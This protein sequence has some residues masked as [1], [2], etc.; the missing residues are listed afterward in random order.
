MLGYKTKRDRDL[1]L[2]CCRW[3]IAVWQLEYGN[4]VLDDFG[5]SGSGVLTCIAKE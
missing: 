2:L 1:F 3:N 5:S 4:T